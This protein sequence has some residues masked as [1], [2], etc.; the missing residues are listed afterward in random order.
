MALHEIFDAEGAE[1]ILLCILSVLLCTPV[2][3]QIHGRMTQQRLLHSKSAPVD[4]GR[5]I[6]GGQLCHRSVLSI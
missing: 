6:N 2:R 3:S 5:T 4:A 1:L